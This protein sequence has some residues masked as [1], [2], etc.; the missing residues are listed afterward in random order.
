MLWPACTNTKSM[1]TLG[2]T[3]LNVCLFWHS[4][5]V[6]CVLC[7]QLH[8]RPRNFDVGRTWFIGSSVFMR[9]PLIRPRQREVA[10]KR[11]AISQMKRSLARVSRVL[12]NIMCA[13]SKGMET[14]RFTAV[15]P[16]SATSDSHYAF[17]LSFELGHMDSTWDR[18]T[19]PLGATGGITR[20]R[21]FF[22]ILELH[23]SNFWFKC[24]LLIYHNVW[25]F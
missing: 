3:F 23:E 8:Q 19:R 12:W 25:H 2:K 18:S 5:G 15:V 13:S 9:F 10:R 21:K 20:R 6:R 22:L 24:P 7:F 14:D 1:L 16:F 17:L 11:E 4:R